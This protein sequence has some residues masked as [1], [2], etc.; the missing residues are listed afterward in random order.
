VLLQ[1]IMILESFVAGRVLKVF[2]VLFK[3]R[4]PVDVLSSSGSDGVSITNFFADRIKDF[5]P[6]VCSNRYAGAGG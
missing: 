2:P 3:K 5:L 1:W 4:T 6:E